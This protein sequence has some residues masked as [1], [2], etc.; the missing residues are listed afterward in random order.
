MN[1][2][3]VFHLTLLFATVTTIMTTGLVFTFAVV[4]MPGIAKFN[5]VQFIRVFQLMDGIIQG[6]DWRFMLVWV[7]SALALLLA[8]VCGYF[9]LNGI[10]SVSLLIACAMYILGLQLPTIL[11][12]VPLNNRLQAVNTDSSTEAELI[13]A[14][15][16]FEDR[17]NRWNNRRTL[18]G[19]I[20]SIILLLVHRLV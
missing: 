5:D 6:N 20:V 4:V 2:E 1:L 17:W 15:D 7:G 14:R 16:D 3:L 13:A 11:I 19:I 12:N 10:A 18:V 8:T 9:Y